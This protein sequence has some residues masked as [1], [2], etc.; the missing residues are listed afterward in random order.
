MLVC[1]VLAE[2]MEVRV[3][4]ELWNKY[5]FQRAWQCGLQGLSSLHDLSQRPDR[6]SPIREGMEDEMR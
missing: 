6:G 3:G 2:K 4:S 5:R 1:A